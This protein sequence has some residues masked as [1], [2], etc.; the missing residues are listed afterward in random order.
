MSV[1]P[2]TFFDVS[3]SVGGHGQNDDSEQDYDSEPVYDY[4]NIVQCFKRMND[5]KI[6]LRCDEGSEI[7]MIPLLVYGS[8]K[9]STKVSR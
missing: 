6:R 8:R 9:P 3:G 2:R 1:H 5:V 4:G 7:T